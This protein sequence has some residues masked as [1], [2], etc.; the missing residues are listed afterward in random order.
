MNPCKIS[1]RVD[2]NTAGHSGVLSGSV[3]D[4]AG[5]Q[6]HLRNGILTFAVPIGAAILPISIRDSSG[7]EVAPSEV[8]VRPNP[9]P[10]AAPHLGD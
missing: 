6:H 1:G 5:Q 2:A 9:T 3:F 10:S 4:V 8:R 7:R